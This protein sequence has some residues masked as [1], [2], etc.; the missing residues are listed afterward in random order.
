[1][2]ERELMQAKLNDFYF[3]VLKDARSLFDEKHLC[4]LS[5]PLLISIS[6]AYLKSP[7]RIMFVGKETN[8]WSGKLK[9]YFSTENAL[10]SMMTRYQ[11]QMN[12]QKWRGRFFSMLNRT[13]RELAG[14]QLDAIAWT[15]L[16]RMDW[17][18]GKG[19]SRNSKGF[20]EVLT[21]IS[22]EILKY[23]V[24]L[25]EPDVIIFACGASY[26]S[27]IKATFPNRTA[28]EPIVKR[29]LWQFKVGEILCFRSRH[30]QAIRRKNSVFKPVEAYYLEIFSL[31]K[32]NFAHRYETP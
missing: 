31:V 9:T 21:R 28:S 2:S 4:E 7:V 17:E 20:S 23:E 29:A 11:S 24:E 6:D 13:A 19:F 16:M 22:Q 27:V 1:M 10:P 12:G 26:D 32:A 30:P 15:N 14:A 25:L 18:H 5:A 8:G 3:T